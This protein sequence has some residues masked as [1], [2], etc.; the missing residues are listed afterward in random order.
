MCE[1]H[2]A[3]AGGQPSC[4]HSSLKIATD[5]VRVAAVEL[6]PKNAEGTI[7]RA[8]CDWEPCDYDD[9]CLDF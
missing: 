5:H 2:G 1:R 6:L 7:S 3:A 4:F 9:G 8:E